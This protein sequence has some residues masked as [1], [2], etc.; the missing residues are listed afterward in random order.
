MNFA[1]LELECENCMKYKFPGK[2]RFPFLEFGKLRSRK[3]DGKNWTVCPRCKVFGYIN[4]DIGRLIANP[5]RPIIGVPHIDELY[6][7]VQWLKDI[8]N[9]FSKE[10]DL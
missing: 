2:N 6:Y 5:G 9:P 4:P 1:D 7:P 8:T 3:G 10:F